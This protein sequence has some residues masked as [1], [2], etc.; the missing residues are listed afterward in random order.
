MKEVILIIIALAGIVAM[1]Y[2]GRPKKKKNVIVSKR[3]LTPM[4]KL[5]TVE[6]TVK[7]LIVAIDDDRKQGAVLGLFIRDRYYIESMTATVKASVDMEDF[8]EE[9]I[10]TNAT[11]NTISITLPYPKV[12]KANILQ[13]K[14]MVI[15]KR[16][17]DFSFEE[18][19]DYR[20]QKQEELD[21]DTKIQQT[22]IDQA[23]QN[24]EE[25]FVAW[26]KTMG[27]ND[28]TINFKKTKEN[29]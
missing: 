28:A 3:T 20:K 23:K 1:I 4:S 11:Q 10:K 14:S 19:F 2:L 9:N 26:L 13:E 29:S 18:I 21:N 8:S 6:A 27:F 12:E 22:I 17:G 25:F 24:T 15:W 5:A 7:T 16:G